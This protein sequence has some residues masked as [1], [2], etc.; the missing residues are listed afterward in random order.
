MMTD[1]IWLNHYPAGMPADIDAD[2]FRSL[3]D[4]FDATVDADR[5]RSLA[6]LFDATVVSNSPT[7]RP[8]TTSAAR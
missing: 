2:R 3:A 7:G 8:I 4:L 6:D 5:F 1:R